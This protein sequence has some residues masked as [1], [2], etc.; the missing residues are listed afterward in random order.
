[1]ATE[2]ALVH[3]L[4]AA[5]GV[6]HANLQAA[7]SW[8]EAVSLPGKSLP[9]AAMGAVCLTY[10]WH[11]WACTFICICKLGISGITDHVH[12]HLHINGARYETTC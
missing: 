6:S 1:M 11:Y 4:Y 10:F 9:D 12:R 3:L 7:V 8:I 2:Y 5:M